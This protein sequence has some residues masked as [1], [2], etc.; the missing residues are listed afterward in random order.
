M[1]VSVALYRHFPSLT[2][3]TPISHTLIQQAAPLNISTCS[4]PA[5]VSLMQLFLPCES[6]AAASFRTSS[7]ALLVDADQEEHVSTNSSDTSEAVTA[8]HDAA[9]RASAVFSGSADIRAEVRPGVAALAASQRSC[10]LTDVFALSSSTVDVYIT[11][12]DTSA[13]FR[14]YADS[15]SEDE[16]PIVSGGISWRS[17]GYSTSFC[18]S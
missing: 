8:M 17:C 6:V 5:L 15:C 3:S 7:S 2:I 9:A 14:N 10:Q 11:A 12:R 13:T 18:S 1:Q 16:S 4:D